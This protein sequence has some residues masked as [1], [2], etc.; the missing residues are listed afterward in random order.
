MEV[1]DDCILL[2]TGVG[3]VVERWWYEKLVNITYAPK[4]KVLCLWCRQKDETILNKFCTKKV[5][6]F[7]AKIALSHVAFE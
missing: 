3:A 2:R 4:T 1:C 5:S 7:V 6:S